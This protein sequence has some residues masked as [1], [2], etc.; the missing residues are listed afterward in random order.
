MTRKLGRRVLMKKEEILEASRKENKNKD[1]AV[2]EAE[3]YAGSIAGRVGATVCCVLSL[4]SSMIAHMMLYSPWMIYFS[5][6]GTNWLVRAIKL[7]KKSDW[8]LAAIFAMLT[9]LAL[10]G[11]I[12]RLSEVAV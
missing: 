11:F 3:R 9:V 7:R 12:D 5:I 6:M 8:V 2:L 4:L 1:L 10:I